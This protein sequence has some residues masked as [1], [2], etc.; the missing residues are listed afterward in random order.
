[1]IEH[2]AHEAFGDD[3]GAFHHPPHL[4]VDAA[5]Q[6]LGGGVGG[7]AALAEGVEERGGG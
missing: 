2:V 4:G 3:A 5:A 7:D 1:M 6:A